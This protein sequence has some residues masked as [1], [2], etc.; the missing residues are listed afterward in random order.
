MTAEMKIDGLLKI[1]FKSGQTRT[2]Y[3]TKIVSNEKEYWKY[4][5]KNGRILIKESPLNPELWA[6]K[7]AEEYFKR[8]MN[9]EIHWQYKL[10]KHHT[11]NEKMVPEEI[12]GS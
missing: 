5:Q 12:L 1:I 8:G 2:I 7:L 6:E 9:G 10:Q 3:A 4:V 11:Q